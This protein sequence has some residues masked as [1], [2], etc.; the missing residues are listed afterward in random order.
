M[1]GSVYHFE[2]FFKKDEDF[3]S[4]LTKHLSWR[5]DKIKMFGKILEQ[6]RKVAWC[7]DPGTKYIY[8]GIKLIAT[9]WSSEVLQIKEQIAKSF[10]VDFNSC[11]INRYRNGDDYMS[12]HSD[13]EK[14]LKSNPQIFSISFGARRDFLLKHNVS[15]EIVKVSL[16]H[17]D[18]LIMEDETQHYWKHSIPKRKNV[19]QERLNLTFRKIY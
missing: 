5:N 4:S 1:D 6:K 14:E 11:L 9:G 19:N 18:L 2:R 13:S 10:D 16:G 7:G 8:S 3:I 17:G 12:Y 15:K